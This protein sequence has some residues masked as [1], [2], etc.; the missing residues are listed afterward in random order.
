[1]STLTNKPP[2]YGGTPSP[3][4]RRRK[5]NRQA[6]VPKRRQSSPARI[7]RSKTF[8]GFYYKPELPVLSSDEEK[9]EK[10]V[11]NKEEDSLAESNKM[12]RPSSLTVEAL[13]VTEEK[14]SYNLSRRR[15][16]EKPIPLTSSVHS[17]QCTCQQDGL[18]TCGSVRRRHTLSPVV[19]KKELMEK[20]TKLIV[21]EYLSSLSPRQLT[22]WTRSGM[23]VSSDYTDGNDFKND[24]SPSIDK[25]S[26]KLNLDAKNERTSSKKGFKSNTVTIGENE[27]KLL[28]Q[29]IQEHNEMQNKKNG[30]RLARSESAVTTEHYTKMKKKLEEM[31]VPIRQWIDEKLK[32]EITKFD[33]SNLNTSPRK[34][35]SPSPRRSPQKK[36]LPLSLT[37]PR[38]SMQMQQ[39]I[40][41]AAFTPDSF[42]VDRLEAISQDIMLNYPELL[43]EAISDILEPLHKDHSITYDLFSNVAKTVYN[44]KLPKVSETVWSRVALV[45]YMVKET[46]FLGNLNDTQ[47]EVLVEH[48]AKF[49][50]D[51]VNETVKNEGG[52]EAI[53]IDDLIY[54][55]TFLVHGQVSSDDE[56]DDHCDVANRKISRHQNN[57]N[58]S[59]ANK[60][61][62]TISDWT[63]YGMAALAVGLGLAYSYLRT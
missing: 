23:R 52:W 59:I 50:S 2:V 46:M 36:Q 41:S 47:L 20:E 4:L 58:G 1:M 11:S 55:S 53:E 13:E 30:K 40:D 63:P 43:Q 9:D 16:T 27:R 34:R 31:Q 32:Q 25:N 38:R 10:P 3:T 12:V 17:S 51:N 57:E 56:I 35:V 7:K 19:S 18:S 37:I 14:K 44:I 49:M 22:A 39:H 8:D 42:A 24:L 21:L 60:V 26:T 54:T 61:T 45:L 62:Q 48:S 5:I 6:P 28:L 29:Q 33:K 15:N